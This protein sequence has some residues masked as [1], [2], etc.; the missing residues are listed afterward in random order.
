[1]FV[2]A[3]AF[4][5]PLNSW[6]V[7]SVT[8]MGGMFEGATAFNQDISGWN[9]SSA[10]TMASMFQFC[11]FN[12]PIGSW[13]VSA[14]TSMQNM[15]SNA[16]SFNQPLS[17]W[18]VSKVT[19]MF[20]VFDSA[21]NFNQDIGNWN[22]SASNS[23]GNFMRGKTPANYSQ[24]YLD[25]IYSGWTRVLLQ[26]LRSIDFGTVKYSSG[27][28]QSVAG[29]GLLSRANQNLVI[30]NCVNNGGGL[31]RVTSVAPQ[32]LV[33]GNK[34][35]I[36]GVLGATQA[37]GPW[38]VTVINTTTIDLQGSTFVSAYTSG[39]VLRTGYGWTI[40]DGGAG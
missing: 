12:Q 26:T 5:Q 15:F 18:D 2:G 4:N 21:T 36:S 27:N 11:P 33:T 9:V 28:T 17:G 35:F 40:T 3:T 22:V 20:G 37:N 32:T 7:S 8:N 23:F 25:S 1:M 19:N 14:C 6:D 10:T 31:I 29:R 13:N 39:G 30:S 38:I 34:V 16:T 24:V